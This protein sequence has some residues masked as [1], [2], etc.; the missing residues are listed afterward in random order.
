MKNNSV[1]F[2]LLTLSYR[3]RDFFRPRISILQEIG[4]K[5]G[6]RM[7]DFGCEPGSYIEPLAKLVSPKGQIYA[8]AF[9]INPLAIRSV[10]QLAQKKSL[11]HKR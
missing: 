11:I 2:Q 4:I 3:I 8:F 1:H 10:R 7:L 6:A 9:E 5:A